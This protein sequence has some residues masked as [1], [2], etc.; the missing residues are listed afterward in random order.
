MTKM[1][2]AL[3]FQLVLTLLIFGR[4]SFNLILDLLDSTVKHVRV[5]T[6]FLFVYSQGDQ[7][8]TLGT[9]QHIF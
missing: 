3:T 7:Q 6:H 5:C 9:T 1:P 8:L 2:N 4:L